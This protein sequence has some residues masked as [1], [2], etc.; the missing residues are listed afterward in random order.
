MKHNTITTK[1]RG[2]RKVVAVV[3]AL[4]VAAAGYGVYATTLTVTGDTNTTLQAGATGTLTQTGSCDTDG[5]NVQQQF[6][7]SHSSGI[8]Y[9][10]NSSG[11][12]KITGIDPSCA[13]KNLKLSVKRSGT[14]TE[15]TPTVAIVAANTGA[16]P[17]TPIVVADA[18]TTNADAY[19]V[20][21][22]A[23]A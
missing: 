5:V 16:A 2:R 13:G 4:G 15:K 11:G 1:R 23:D 21:I 17:A 6:A 12:H 18:T 14:F 10:V 9:G 3:G 7:H 20:Y 22:G 19:S 8:G